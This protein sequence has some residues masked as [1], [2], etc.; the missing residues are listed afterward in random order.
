MSI[1]GNAGDVTTIGLVMVMSIRCCQLTVQ[2]SSVGT[3]FTEWIKE[4]TFNSGN[5][6]ITA[7]TIWSAGTVH[8]PTV[9]QETF[10][11]RI[12]ETGV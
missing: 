1:I 4:I 10:A 11:I 2:T 9:V 3:V 8:Q 6:W 12:R 7:G 5:V